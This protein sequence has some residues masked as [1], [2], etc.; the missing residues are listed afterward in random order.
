LCFSPSPDRL[1][2]QVFVAEAFARAA[3]KAVSPRANR[4]DIR[5]RLV[6][7]R[8]LMAGVFARG[9]I[10]GGGALLGGALGYGAPYYA[11]Y[12]EYGAFIDY[13]W[14]C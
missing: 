11:Q 9:G 1:T 3:F 13:A 4:S 5:P 12:D 14:A 10:F 2:L 8:W 6:D 7:T